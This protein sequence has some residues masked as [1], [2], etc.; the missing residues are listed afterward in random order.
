MTAASDHLALRG[1]GSAIVRLRRA[2]DLPGTLWEAGVDRAAYQKKREDI[3]RAAQAD[4]CC[5]TNPVPG[6]ARELQQVMKA[7]AP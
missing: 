3:L 4:P 2:L 1:L 6:T 5:Q 7:V